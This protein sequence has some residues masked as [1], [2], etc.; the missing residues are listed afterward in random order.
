[1]LEMLKAAG[2]KR[3]NELYQQLKLQKIKRIK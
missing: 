1:M 3:R 2:I